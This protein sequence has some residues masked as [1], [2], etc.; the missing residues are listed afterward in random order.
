MSY[1]KLSYLELKED[2][3]PIGVRNWRNM[4]P[5]LDRKEAF[6][7]FIM[8][9]A[10][11]EELRIVSANY[12][13]LMYTSFEK[14][15]ELEQMHYSAQKVITDMMKEQQDNHRILKVQQSM[16]SER[17]TSEKVNIGTINGLRKEILILTKK[18]G[19]MCLKAENIVNC[20]LCGNE[21]QKVSLLGTKACIDCT[22]EL[23]EMHLLKSGKFKKCPYCGGIELKSEFMPLNFYRDEIEVCTFY[24]YNIL[25]QLKGINPEYPHDRITIYEKDKEILMN[26]REGIEKK[27]RERSNFYLEQS[28]FSY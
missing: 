25:C 27:N 22:D 3:E 4:Y 14:I 13:D 20:D 2:I 9:S 28:G 1:K 5:L 15:A 10:S 8:D 23:E 19:E 6:R 26:D 17:D 21:F 16:L 18:L 11:I 12:Q 24:C 7:A